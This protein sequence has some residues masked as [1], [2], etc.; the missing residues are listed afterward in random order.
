MKK[1]TSIILIVAMLLSMFTITIPAVAAGGGSGNDL[2][3]SVG[4]GTVIYNDNSVSGGWLDPSGVGSNVN[5]SVPEITGPTNLPNVNGTLSG[6]TFSGTITA[7]PAPGANSVTV[8]GSVN[9]SSGATATVAPGANSVAGGNSTTV[10]NTTVNAGSNVSLTVPGSVNVSSGGAATVAPGANSVTAGSNVSLTVPGS[11]TSNATAT[12]PTDFGNNVVTADNRAAYIAQLGADYI[13]VVNSKADGDGKP[14]NAVTYKQMAD[15]GK[16]YLY[17]DITVTTLRGGL[18]QNITLDGCGYSVTVSRP[19]FDKTTNITVKN[20]TFK[21]TLTNI[22]GTEAGLS[23]LTAWS[24]SGTCNMYNIT[25]EVETI[26]G[27]TA[28]SQN[29]SAIGLT[30]KDSV[31]ENVKITGNM[32]LTSAATQF[33]WIGGLVAQADGN[34]TIRNVVRTGDI[35]FDGCTV[36]LTTYALGGLVGALGKNAKME[37]CYNTGDIV[38]KN[39]AKITNGKY[40]GGIAAFCDS[41]AS[42]T[43]CVNTGDVPTGDNAGGVLGY[44]N[45]A[46]TMTNCA[47]SGAVSGTT[48]G[49]VV[50]YVSST[51]NVENCYNSGKITGTS[52]AGG[53]AGR[54]VGAATLTSLVN[55]GDVTCNG[56]FAGG[57]TAYAQAAVTMTGCVNNANLTGGKR[58]GGILGIS[59]KTATLINCINGAAS[60]PG[61]LDA[62]KAAANLKTIKVTASGGGDGSVGGIVGDARGDTIVSGCVNYATIDNSNSTGG[63]SIFVGGIAGRIKGAAYIGYTAANTNSVS[64]TVTANFGNVSSKMYNENTVQCIAGIVGAVI[65]ETY[66]TNGFN[67]GE[68]K[69]NEKSGSTLGAIGG[70]L[71]APA[72]GKTANI[73]NCVNTGTIDGTTGGNWGA[74]GIVGEGA[75]PNLTITNCKNTGTIKGKEAAGILAHIDAVSANITNC[76]NEGEITG[77]SLV[78]G[79]LAKSGNASTITGCLNDGKV[80]CSGGNAGGIIGTYDVAHTINNCKNGANATISG[81]YAGGI[82]GYADIAVNL[83]GLTNEGTITGTTQSGGIIAFVNGDATISNCVNNANVTGGSAAGGLVA[84]IAGKAV[85][86]NNING[87]ASNPEGFDA[88]KA[89]ANNKTVKT[90]VAVSDDNGVLGGLVGNVVGTAVVSG[91]VNYAKIDNSA[92]KSK[93]VGGIIARVTSVAYIGYTDTN[94]DA[95]AT[96][97]TA[98]FGDIISGQFNG[99]NTQ[100]NGGIVGFTREGG[101]VNNCLNV[102]NNTMTG[103]ATSPWNGI[104]GIVGVPTRDAAGYILT[105]T[106]CQN[107]GAINTGTT[108]RNS[109]GGIVG[110]VFANT[111]KVIITNCKNE[112]TVHGTLAGGIAGYVQGKNAEVTNCTNTMAV[113]SQSSTCGGIVA[114]VT[115]TATITGCKNEGTVT[116]GGNKT[117]GITGHIGGALTVKNTVNEGSVSGK[118]YIGGVVSYV[119]GNANLV[120]CFNGKNTDDPDKKT[121]V[122]KL[123]GTAGNCIGGIAGYVGGTAIVDGAINYSDIYNWVDGDRTS[124]DGGTIR[125]IAKYVGGIIGQVGG[126]AYIGYAE[127]TA[128]SANKTLGGVVAN[129]GDVT[130]G[131]YMTNNTQYVGGVLG[132]AT[133]GGYIANA[134]NNGIVTV[135]EK[136]GGTGGVG[137]IVGVSPSTGKTLYVT[138]CQ[139]NGEIRAIEEADNW[140]VAGIVG[141]AFHG[142][143]Y[144]DNCLNSEEATIT[145]GNYAGGIFGTDSDHTPTVEITNCTNK[146]AVSGTNLVGGILAKIST[147]ATI[148]GC[149]NDGDVTCSGGN[150][151]GIIGTY[152]VAH[153]INN[154]KNGANATITGTYA[155]GIIGNATIAISLDGLVNE[156]TVSGTYAGG[157]I[158]YGAAAVNAQDTDADTDTVSVTNSGTVKGVV[159]AGGII[160]YAGAASTITGASTTTTSSVTSESATA[161]SETSIAIGGIIGKVAGAATISNCATGGT[162]EAK[163]ISGFAGTAFYGGIIGWSGG[164][165][166]TNCTNNADIT[167]YEGAALT[168]LGGIR[169][170]SSWQGNYDNCDNKG[171]IT[172][173]AGVDLTA[174]DDNPRN[175]V[176]GILGSASGPLTFKNCDNTGIIE[177]NAVAGDGDKAIYVG[178]IAGFVNNNNASHTKTFEACT[179]GVAITVADGYAGGIVGTDF[180]SKI[181]L[182]NCKNTGAISSADYAGGLIGILMSELE[183]KTNSSMNKGAVSGS[184]YGGGIVGYISAAKTYDFSLARNEGTISSKNAGGVVGYVDKAATIKNATNNGAISSSGNDT[185]GA[186][187]LGGIVASTKGT[188]TIQNCTNYGPVTAGQKT[189]NGLT[190]AAGIVGLADGD[191]TADRI[192]VTGCVNTKPVDA[193]VIRCNVGGIVGDAKINATVQNCE[194]TKDAKITSYIDATVVSAVGGIIGYVRGYKNA[195]DVIISGCKNSADIA[196][197]GGNGKTACVG[198]IVGRICATDWETD[199]SVHISSCENN[200][201]ISALSGV[202]GPTYAGG[203]VGYYQAQKQGTVLTVSGSKNSGNISAQNTAGGMVGGTYVDGGKN[204][205][206]YCTL[207]IGV[208]K[209]GVLSTCENI[210]NVSA[211]N[212]GGAFGGDNGAGGIVIVLG[213]FVNNVAEGGTGITATTNAGGVIGGLATGEKCEVSVAQGGA[214]VNNAPVSG[215]TAGG[216]IGTFKGTVTLTN[217]LNGTNATVSGTNAGG[218][219]GAT[220]VDVTLTNVVNEGAVS[221]T[222]YAGGIAG[223][224]GAGLTLGANGDKASVTNKGEVSGNCYGGGIVGYI[225]AANTY[226]FSLAR[227]EGTISSKNA[228]GVVG[229]VD[230]A[231]TIKNA[232]NNGAITPSTSYTGEVINFGGI[233]ASTSGAVTVQNCTNYGPVTVDVEG[234]S[235]GGVG[236]IIGLVTGNAASDKATISNCVN[237]GTVDVNHRRYHTGGIIGMTMINSKIE[238]CQNK[239]AVTAKIDSTDNTGVAG[240]VGHLRGI[241]SQGSIEIIN[242]K[243]SAKVS[244]DAG[245]GNDGTWI[246]GIAGRIQGKSW[247]D[248]YTVI[249]NG[250]FNEGEISATGSS[251]VTFVGGL[252]GAPQI[253]NSG[254]DITII[255]SKNSGTITASK[256]YAG[257]FIGSL[258]TENT[259]GAGS[260]VRIGVDKDGNLGVCENSGKVTSPANAGG[261]IGGQHTRSRQ[262]ELVLGKL[263]NNP[264]ANG[265]G[266]SGSSFAGGIVGEFGKNASDVLTLANGAVLVNNAPV[267][268]NEAGG[269]F[270]TLRV[271]AT[272]SGC[273]NNGNISDCSDSAGGIVGWAEKDITIQNSVNN[274][275]VSGK[276]AG[277]MVGYAS[278]AITVDN[279]INTKGVTGTSDAGGIVGYAKGEAIIRNSKNEGTVGGADDAGGFI[280]EA[281]AAVTIKN[282]ANLANVSGKT[283]VGGFVAQVGGNATFVNCVNGVAHADGV[284]R[285]KITKLSGT[286]G[287]QIGGIAG[288]IGGTAIV[289]GAI[290]YADIYNWVDED[291]VLDTNDNA[292][293]R[294]VAKHAGGIIGQVGGAAYIGYAADT[295]TSDNRTLGGVVANLGDVT[296]GTY[297]SN[298]TQYVGGVIAYPAGGGYIANALNKGTVTVNEKSG[299]TGGAGGIVGVAEGATNVANCVNEGTIST[300][301]LATNWAAAGIVGRAFSSLTAL[302][303]NNCKNTGIIN[304]EIA[305]YAGGIAGFIDGGTVEIKNC[306]NTQNIKA[307]DSAGGLAGKLSG[308]ASFYNCLNSGVVG[309]AKY[310]GGI[311]AYVGGKVT[312]ADDVVNNNSISGNYAGGLLGYVAGTV[313]ISDT[314]SDDISATNYGD[315]TGTDCIGGLVGFGND[316]VTVK[317]ATVSADVDVKLEG[318]HAS[319][320]YSRAGGVIGNAGGVTMENVEVKGGTV[321]VGAIDNKEVYAGGVVGRGT[322]TYKNVTNR[323][324]VTVLSTG[325]VTAVGGVVGRFAWISSMNN[326][327]NYG[328][329]KAEN[330]ATVSNM[331]GIIGNASGK[332]DVEYCDNNGEVTNESTSAVNIAGIIGYANNGDVKTF[333]NCTNK[334]AISTA[335]GYAAGIFANSDNFKANATG[336]INTAAITGGSYAGGILGYVGKGAALENCVNDAAVTGGDYAAGMV[337]YVADGDTTITGCTN[338]GAIEATTTSS[339]AR[340]VGGILGYSAKAVEFIKCTNNNTIT[341][342]V[343]KFHVG[344]IAGRI[345]GNATFKG[346]KNT[347]KGTISVYINESDMIGA[348]GLLGYGTG[349]KVTF[350]N[351]EDGTVCQNDA[352]VELSGGNGKSTLLGGIVGRVFNSELTLEN[353][354]NTGDIDASKAKTSNGGVGGLVGLYQTDNSGGSTTV[355]NVVITGGQNSGV[356]KGG[357]YA[358]G[359][360][361]HDN[362]NN[363]GLRTITITGFKNLKSVEAGEVAG[364]IVGYVSTNGKSVVTVRNSVNNANVTGVTNAGGIIGHAIT[365]IIDGCINGA[366]ENAATLEERKAAANKIT[367]SKTG[368]NHNV[369]GVVGY[370]TGDLVVN[371]TTNYAQLINGNA[372]AKYLGGIAGQVAGQTYMGYTPASVE[373]AKADGT[374]L[375]SELVSGAP[376]EN[377]GYIETYC[378][379]VNNTQYVGGIIGYASA[380]GFIANAY[381][382]AEIKAMEENTDNSGAFD[383]TWGGLGGIVGV[384][385]G[386]LDIDTAANCGALT[387]NADDDK[388][389]W[390]VGG[391]VGRGFDGSAVT[392]TNAHNYVD[393]SGW[394]VGGIAGFIAGSLVVKDSINDGKITVDSDYDYSAVGGI[395]GY[396]SKYAE[397]INVTNNKDVIAPS[398]VLPEL[399]EGEEM[400]EDV[401][402]NSVFAMGGIAGYVGGT[403]KLVAAVNNGD[404]T[405]EENVRIY[406]SDDDKGNKFG[407]SGILGYSV[408]KV[409]I[410][411]ADNGDDTVNNGDVTVKTNGT[412]LDKFDVTVKDEETGEDVKTTEWRETPVGINVGG[413]VG[414]AE[415]GIDAD[416]A[417]NNGVISSTNYGVHIGGIVGHA[418]GN[419]YYK[420]LVNTEDATINGFTTGGTMWGAGGVVGYAQGGTVSFEGCINAADV[421]ANEN[422]NGTASRYAGIVGRVTAGVFTLDNSRNSGSVINRTDGSNAAGGIVG[423]HQGGWAGIPDTITITNA[424]S[425]GAQ[426]TACYAGGI[427]GSVMTDNDKQKQTIVTINNAYN[428][429]AVTGNEAAGGITA[430]RANGNP[431]FAISDVANSG[432]VTATKYAGGIIAYVRNVL[433]VENATNN[434]NVFANSRAGGIAGYATNNAIFVNCINGYEKDGIT[435]S[436]GNTA[437]GGGDLGG[438]AGGIEGNAV[439]NGCANNATIDNY[440]T[441]DPEK[442]TNYEVAKFVGGI[443]GRVKGVT[444]MNVQL[445]ALTS[446]EEGETSMMDKWNAFLV[447]ADQYSSAKSAVDTAKEAVTKA[448]TAAEKDGRVLDAEYQNIK[449]KEADYAAKVEAYELKT[450]EYNTVR[451]ELLAQTK[452]FDATA[453]V[454]EGLVINNGSIFSSRF[455]KDHTQ[456]VGG[457]AGLT[458]HGGYIHNVANTGDMAANVTG[459]GTCSGLAGIVGVAAD[460]AYVLNITNAYN[461]GDLKATMTNAEGEEST[462]TKWGVAGIVG[463]AFATLVEINVTKAVN[464]GDMTGTYAGGITGYIQNGALNFTGVTNYGAI[465]GSTNAAGVAAYA[466]G[467]ITIDGGVNKG[468]IKSATHAGGIVGNYNKTVT[469]ATVVISGSVNDGTVEAVNNAGGII[470]NA[471]ASGDYTITNSVNLAEVTGAKVTPIATLGNITDCGYLKGTVE[472][473]YY[474]ATEMAD[475]E[476]LI[477]LIGDS[478]ALGFEDALL[479]KY[480][481][482]AEKKVEGKNEV[483]YLP[484]LW[485]STHTSIANGSDMLATYRDMIANNAFLG[486]FFT[487]KQINDMTT[488]LIEAENDFLTFHE[489]QDA[490]RARLAEAAAIEADAESGK[491]LYTAESWAAFQKALSEYNTAA[492]SSDELRWSDLKP[493]DRALTAAING[494]VLGGTILTAEQF[495]N[496]DGR[497]GIFTLEADIE[498]TAPLKNFKGVIIG[499]GHTITLKGNALFEAVD[500]ATDYVD[501]N[502]NKTNGAFIYNLKVNG[503]TGDAKSIFG[504]AAGNATIQGVIIAVQSVDSA[505]VFHKVDK[506]AAVEIYDIIS[507]A[508]AKDA[509]LVSGVDSK[510]VTIDGALVMAKADSLTDAKNAKISNAYLGGVIYFDGN[511]K[512]TTD[513]EVFASGKVA[514]EINQSFN[515]GAELY[516]YSHSEMTTYLLVQNVGKDVL[517][518]MGKPDATGSNVVVPN[519]NGGFKNNAPT[520]VDKDNIVSKPD[521]PDAEPDL[522]GIIIAESMIAKLDSKLYTAMS[523]ATLQ[524]LLK[525]AQVAAASG[526]QAAIDFATEALMN[527]INALEK[528]SSKVE[529]GITLDTAALQNLMSAASGLD[530]NAYTASSWA[531]LV[532]LIEKANAALTSGDQNRVD[533]VI[534]GLRIALDSLVKVKVEAEKP[535]QTPVD[536][537]EATEPANKEGGCGSVLSG[538]AVVMA[539]VIALG[540]GVA[541]KKKEDEE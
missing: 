286:A 310:A 193:N 46:V 515:N 233:I 347:D 361:G 501:L 534:A 236:G 374:V 201:N 381:N 328:V 359:A 298:N 56:S 205:K 228:G 282:S 111:D 137:G 234:K 312:S 521:A 5:L 392:V 291:R 181:V 433:T 215:A 516:G 382:Y 227:N 45:G 444:F 237:D 217:C 144:I 33:V 464:I 400:P 117:G 9:A 395:A 162:I 341:T 66:I 92:S 430:G 58:L 264:N 93:Y 15:N 372:L 123:S 475:R 69:A 271:A 289:D 196:H 255:N 53:V 351:A 202:T 29:L 72:S 220:T 406:A 535:E 408:G 422:S 469:D 249:M 74:A 483:H 188:V 10:G 403:T 41:G 166:L 338:N 300:V 498:I 273:I 499:N 452:E 49:G 226:D 40:V 134:L 197:D 169:G 160:G 253:S 490:I 126:T 63:Y 129:L 380:G 170:R 269:I 2:V 489:L 512:S 185:T 414:Y 135:N 21:G 481:E 296:S 184:G 443:V 18:I 454:Y 17:E 128:T 136:S 383:D 52:F 355:H 486:N 167:L 276:Y 28:P 218:I 349:A 39:G 388:A 216:I 453:P 82:I 124:G 151:G 440:A 287:K 326:C 132:Y 459:G 437:N 187:N 127:N 466:E 334:K 331:G 200:G 191:K 457:I 375:K 524:S 522:S 458:R 344:G 455:N 190:S 399:E 157:I 281:V 431:T 248:N 159:N 309:G 106:N 86:V 131:T 194:N 364:G 393:L 27:N 148:T 474:L 121:Q 529:E 239:K 507:F 358:G 183:F 96:A 11:S 339:S 427:I 94:K 301:D 143:L 55:E 26:T 410:A 177:C 125:N 519:G 79:I 54:V 222:G 251:G 504:A 540:T 362:G 343:N 402:V 50:A 48:V 36:N 450:E 209:D 272:L 302:N 163:A 391:I 107:K 324:N 240:I 245:N 70:I 232:T 277:G 369:G 461:S 214:V 95:V 484:D 426:I 434:G 256:G 297:K 147:A 230:K 283:K 456:Y 254:V 396:V 503:E 370:V 175:S 411:P 292:T 62:Q 64:G 133:G 350:K 213:N 158:G 210:G 468:E 275:T 207:K 366:L 59:E 417:I 250:C 16:Y 532:S 243:N 174:K 91:C 31:I 208:D 352:R 61:T 379:S 180:N 238:N 204:P 152:D 390:G 112:A 460:G 465:N 145:G 528:I 102:G 288:N 412:F 88:Q 119:G 539:A 265:E 206:W 365:A 23:P 150:A 173:N 508:D 294:S 244:Q 138:G 30:A 421:L 348:G 219:I 337:A 363:G 373:A 333:T 423:N 25:S 192:T 165:N 371:G 531:L 436:T 118:N 262:I 319:E 19:M 367:I 505:A 146:G 141:R 198:G 510:Y 321:K 429:G 90:T 154:C 322:G 211:N 432:D 13:P 270:G 116:G 398:P 518:V 278:A 280:G 480:L 295:A 1:T 274:G 75:T 4:N 451:E 22:D 108:A 345:A 156:G 263:V 313:N 513:K 65:L 155:G 315:I 235:A 258:Y 299:G 320:T 318:T 401:D 336:C 60:N 43:N 329:V 142:T 81:A 385:N 470:G 223:K 357:K 78:G 186:I 527:G 34:T 397:F 340:A 307:T 246:G 293:Q 77:T 57:V 308:N 314:D 517:P 153:T 44:A 113:S 463:R 195:G 257:G 14:A 149:L 101:Y 221:A 485:E 472:D 247:G 438:I 84:W 448:Q 476:A 231:A 335:N 368:Q 261:F 442:V 435:I 449:A 311:A 83:S 356:I 467:N 266:I 122:I 493:Y 110:R 3:G 413:V 104:G 377:Y 259:A 541:L 130:S 506:D 537:P 279:C 316:N 114:E 446:A 164:G 487:Q 317:N 384:A 252:I 35:I 229:Y 225:S 304:S 346:C 37:N 24:H 73:S 38:L 199:V 85:F 494:L 416:G 120:N 284:A 520:L 267:S 179:N 354:V 20:I 405:A 418:G 428:T 67:A 477:M 409:T 496:I 389:F 447:L 500:G 394:R 424:Y 103:S 327:D 12:V 386:T 51:A 538:V 497:E 509:A 80:T 303:V 100:Y 342:K 502:G 488:E 182:N 203:I 523:W 76:T 479:A 98:N 445:D 212:A 89:A 171:N 332:L 178:G 536:T 47:N 415:G 176:G 7:T 87:A 525:A 425:T 8:P 306:T 99:S 168:S 482:A 404:V 189:T 478:A 224:L 511:G 330:G 172:V 68:I 387:F 115:G 492:Y 514:Y 323:A 325:L 533:Q 441:I 260:I 97:V 491:V 407:V 378:F 32:T 526:D 42:F 105:I 462:A 419:Q 420:N 109:A 495:A 530:K 439:F 360:L 241:K 161:I 140:G 71:G 139:N 471:S 353:C 6:P 290:N 473:D 376:V 305:T 285:T 268:G 242:C